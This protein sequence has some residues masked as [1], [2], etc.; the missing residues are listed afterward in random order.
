MFHRFEWK[1]KPHNSDEFKL[2]ALGFTLDASIDKLKFS[3]EFE[4]VPDGVYN[5]I[6]IQGSKK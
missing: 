5:A 6:T 2:L 1:Y 4:E 3:S